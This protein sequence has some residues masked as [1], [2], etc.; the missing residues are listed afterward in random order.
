[1]KKLFS[2]IILVIFLV[3]SSISFAM[4]EKRCYDTYRKYGDYYTGCND[5]CRGSGGKS[6]IRC[7]KKRIR[8]LNQVLDQCDVTDPD[9]LE[10][11]IERLEQDLEHAIE[12]A[13]RAGLL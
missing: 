11:K 6:C 9:R 7:M 13:R 12:R 10:I 2:G 8:K 1:M 5:P 4:D 3:C